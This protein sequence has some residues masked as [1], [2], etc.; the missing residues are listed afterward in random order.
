MK[1]KSETKHNGELGGEHFRMF[2]GAK[3]KCLTH[4]RNR[5]RRLGPSAGGAGQVEM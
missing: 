3:R 1:R 4:G 5:E 2:E